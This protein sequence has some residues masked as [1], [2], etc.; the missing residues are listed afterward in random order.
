MVRKVKSIKYEGLVNGT[1]QFKSTPEG[2]EEDFSNLYPRRHTLYVSKINRPK[3][4]MIRIERDKD[5]KYD[6]PRMIFVSKEK[7]TK[8]EFIEEVNKIAEKLF[9]SLESGKKDD[10]LF[11]KSN[12]YIEMYEETSLEEIEKNDRFH[13]QKQA[14]QQMFDSLFIESK[15]EKAGF[16]TLGKILDENYL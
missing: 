2:E 1:K 12:E 16:D 5:V 9:M 14:R 4:M 15:N 6:W 10:E 13:L 7:K 11:N 3:N 8:A